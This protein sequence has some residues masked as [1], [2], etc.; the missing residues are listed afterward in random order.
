MS[1]NEKLN[2]S[3]FKNT[4]I[5][6][7]FTL[8]FILIILFN[9]MIYFSIDDFIREKEEENL[10][11]NV[12]LIESIL[13]NKKKQ[14]SN[15]AKILSRFP[16]L[17]NIN[18]LNLLKRRIYNLNSSL[19][20]RGIQIWNNNLDKTFEIGSGFELDKKSELASSIVKIIKDGYSVAFFNENDFFDLQ[21]TAFSY[22][23]DEYSIGIEGLVS[24]SEAI[25]KDSI[26][27]IAYDIDG[28][29][30][31]Y[32]TDEIN[33][34]FFDSFNKKRSVSGKAYYIKRQKIEEKKYLISYLPV[35][36]F[37]D[38]PIGYYT[39]L[40]SESSRKNLIYQL[41]VFNVF[42]ILFFIFIYKKL[43]FCNAPGS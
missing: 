35:K 6:L 34:S 27:K 40:V 26:N 36:D 43:I 7:F 21:I 2:L 4:K 25:K 20:V 14:L 38:K 42:V 17:K 30:N 18:D 41:I 1:F 16:D 22:I 39:I 31:F 8:F 32:S 19:N 37:F 15:Y 23:Y 12:T 29:I 5:I 10:L 28:V 3:L 9:L 13:E 11:K 24:I 33:E